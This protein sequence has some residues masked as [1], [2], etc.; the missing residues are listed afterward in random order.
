M[1]IHIS[2]Q[3]NLWIMAYMTGSPKAEE[4]YNADMAAKW[5]V[6][7]WLTTSG[8]TPLI[9]VFTQSSGDLVYNLSVVF[10]ALKSEQNYLRIQDDTLG[11][12]ESSTDIATKGS[13]YLFV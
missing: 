5:G 8:S 11:V 2:S 6:L 4:K 13:I 3:L 9:D 7:G 12:T 10:Q 1:R